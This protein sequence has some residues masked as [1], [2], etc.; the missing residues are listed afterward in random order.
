MSD[1]LATLAAHGYISHRSS[2]LANSSA[3]I[4]KDCAEKY[5][6][7]PKRTF[8]RLYFMFIIIN[9]PAFVV[10]SKSTYIISSKNVVVI[11]IIIYS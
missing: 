6:G 2:I 3:A 7:L 1:F 5:S 10:T 9:V 8:M 11:I 4:S